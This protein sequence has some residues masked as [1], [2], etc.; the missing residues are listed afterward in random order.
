VLVL[1]DFYPVFSTW[2][3][4]GLKFDSSSILM[5]C[6]KMKDISFPNNIR[7]MVLYNTMI[8]YYLSGIIFSG[9]RII[10]CVLNS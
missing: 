5:M 8:H 6:T 9:Y 1:L 7:L 3:A 4:G 2:T 10:M